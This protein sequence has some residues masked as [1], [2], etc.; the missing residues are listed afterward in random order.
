MLNAFLLD[1][2][3]VDIELLTRINNVLADGTRAYGGGFAE[4]MTGEARKR[5]ALE[6]RYVNCI[7]SARA[8]TSGGSPATT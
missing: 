3:D 1:H 6:Y 4:A 2:V 5:G 8:R 7:A